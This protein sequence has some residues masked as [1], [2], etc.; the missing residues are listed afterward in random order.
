MAHLRIPA[1][2][3]GGLFLV[4]PA[5]AQT[6]DDKLDA[7]QRQIQQLQQE[8]QGL[9]AQNLAASPQGA[10]PRVTLYPAKGPAISTA[11]GQTSIQL[12]S[13]LQFDVGDY[14]DVTPQSASSVP[15]TLQSGVNA[16]RARL[17]IVGKFYG[18]WDYALVYDFGGSADSLTNSG[19][20]T[21][22]IEN[23]YVS[24]TGLRPL[25]FD[26]GYQN[27]PWTLD[28]ATVSTDIL[29]LERAS[30]SIIATNIAAGDFRSAAGA[31][32]IDDRYFA[33][34][35]ATGPVSGVPHNQGEQVGALGRFTYQVV[36]TQESSLHLGLDG[37][38]LLKAASVN[39]VRTLALSDRPELRIDP[40]VVLNTGSLINVRA[41]NVLGVEGA[42]AIRNFFVQGE[43]YHFMVE[44]DRL[45]GL[46][47]DGGYAEASWVLTGERHTYVPS[48]GAYSGVLPS[49]PLS[50]GGQGYGA[51]EIA[52]RVSLTDLD[53]R[54]GSATQGVAGGKQTVWTLGL[55]WY[56]D[57]YVRLSLNYLHGDIDR[58]SIPAGVGTGLS[59][60][61]IAMRSQVAF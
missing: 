41:A 9:K 50:L 11:D 32:L 40:T 14:L 8:L 13:R 48:S 12:T 52:A 27:V 37:E 35:W 10:A 36:E 34:L 28:E 1:A 30:P 55:N 57:T 19:A 42:Y 26:I 6:T 29:F 47:F 53:D 31:R 15:S 2:I 21:S 24:Y 61:A 33:A 49:H 60:D 16:R 20:N 44:R 58:R 25:A 18:D 46:A 22:G 45:P 38:R 51:F 17:G 7:L 3:F 39:G 56:V 23:A 43:Y 4:A 54:I 5:L 59:F